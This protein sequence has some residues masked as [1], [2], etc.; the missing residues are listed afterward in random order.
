MLLCVLCLLSMD[1]R[2]L[3]KV[4][5]IE[6]YKENDMNLEFTVKS[7]CINHAW[8]KAINYIRSL[9]LDP[10]LVEYFSVELM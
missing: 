9:G 2:Y 1:L 10:D 7:D 5:F 8:L 3:I 4:F 6:T